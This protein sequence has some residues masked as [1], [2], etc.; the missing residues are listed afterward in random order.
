M[1]SDDETTLGISHRFN[2]YKHASIP[3]EE[4]A[5]LIVETRR[6]V[7]GR[8]AATEALEQARAGRQN[9]S[10]SSQEGLSVDAE[11]DMVM[12]S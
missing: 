9:G 2:S 10:M 6:S 5:Q 8:A 1:E 4:E 12:G 7:D 11:Y 3:P